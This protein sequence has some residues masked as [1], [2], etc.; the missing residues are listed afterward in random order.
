MEA[1]EETEEKGIVHVV[2]DDFSVRRGIERLLRSAG[3]RAV[4]HESALEFL[5][6]GVEDG[7]VC[8]IL[9][10]RLPGLNGLDL[11]RELLTRGRELSIVFITGHGDVPMSVEAM[12]AGAVDFL[13]KPFN[14]EALLDA[15]KR[16]IRQDAKRKARQ[17]IVGEIRLRLE[18]LTSREREVLDLVVTGMLNKQVGAELGIAEKTV[19]VHRSRVMEKMEVQ[20]LA[21]LV[22]ITEYFR[23]S[24][25]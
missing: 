13:P 22:R 2:D 6:K 20:S 23:A 24:G 8:L 9:D 18:R 11:Q 5:E 12:K 17:F 14:D 7:P 25:S 19:K 15:V 4:C 21:E 1:G 3:H 16:G 10:V